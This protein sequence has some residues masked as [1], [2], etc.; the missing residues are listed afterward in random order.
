[1][2]YT[3]LIIILAIIVIGWIV[4]QFITGKRKTKALLEVTKPEEPKTPTPPETPA[5]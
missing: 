1:M 5:M 2:K 4:Y 3:L